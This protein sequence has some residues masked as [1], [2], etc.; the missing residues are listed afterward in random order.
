MSN[1]KSRFMSMTI[2]TNVYRGLDEPTVNFRGSKA[3]DP[4]YDYILTKVPDTSTE[5]IRRDLFKH[6]YK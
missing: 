4:H 5:K 3:V 1:L 6:V 2:I